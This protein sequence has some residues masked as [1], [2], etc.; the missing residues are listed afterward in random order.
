MYV[1]FN[2]LQRWVVGSGYDV[3][4][5]FGGVGRYAMSCMI[6]GCSRT[7]PRRRLLDGAG[8]CFAGLWLYERGLGAVEA[9]EEGGRGAAQHEW[10]RN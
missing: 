1:C 5:R 6:L 9:E 2:R 7:L 10:R 4:G 3:G 8:H